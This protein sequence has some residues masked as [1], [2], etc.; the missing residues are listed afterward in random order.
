MSL[1]KAAHDVVEEVRA[2]VPEREITID[3]RSGISVNW[4][5]ARISQA[6]TNLLSNAVEHSSPDSV[7]TLRVE[8]EEDDAVISVHNEGVPLTAEQ[9]DGIF[10]SMKGATK[11]TSRASS[12]PLGHLGLGLYIA[13]R[14]VD[15]HDGRIEVESTESKGTTFRMVIPLGPARID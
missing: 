10:G 9:M 4:D 14:I 7:V 5:C 15:A 8:R 12:D 11:S 6:I 1:G 13:E 2:G 3:A